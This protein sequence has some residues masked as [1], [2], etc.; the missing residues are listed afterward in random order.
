MRRQLLATSLVF[1]LAAVSMPPASVEAGGKA[2]YTKLHRKGKAKTVLNDQW[3][4]LLKKAKKR[5]KPVVVMFSADWCAPCKAIK[6]FMNSSTA[7]QKAL[8]KGTFVIID[9][10]EYRGPAHR[11]INGVNPTKL[12]T[13]VRVDYRGNRV[14]QCYGSDLGLLSEDS[15]AHNI[16]RLFK[17]KSPSKPFYRGKSKVESELQRKQSTAQDRKMKGVPEI[18]AK[19]RT[20]AGGMFT[21]RLIIRNHDGPRRWYILPTSIGAKLKTNPKVA[22]WEQVKWDEHVRANFRRYVGSPGFIAIPVAGYGKVDLGRWTMF[23]NPA[24]KTLTV[25]KLNRLVV[26]G[27]AAEFMQKL[28]YELTLKKSGKHKVTARGAGGKVEMSVAHKF[29][30]PLRK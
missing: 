29:E 19:I 9:V 2:H 7:V 6:D 17:G 3:A 8:R 30:V 1:A 21:M 11:L 25:W 18:E 20:A 4:A 5:R 15:V 16:K 27:D 12:P 26:D 22:H 14:V 13:I 28:P 24:A 23:G 10:D